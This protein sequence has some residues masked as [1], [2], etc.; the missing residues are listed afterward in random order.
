[1]G[2]DRPGGRSRSEAVLINQRNMYLKNVT[3]VYNSMERK[4]ISR[5]GTE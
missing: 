4:S 1:M 2:R 5:T 3:S